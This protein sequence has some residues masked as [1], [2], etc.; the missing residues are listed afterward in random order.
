MQNV[1]NSLQKPNRMSEQKCLTVF[2]KDN[3][4]S[5]A[6]CVHIF[7]LPLIWWENV[8]FV[9]LMKAK[10]TCKWIKLYRL[11]YMHYARARVGDNL[12]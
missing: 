11:L 6:Q 9:L 5:L 8:N 7:C 2:L 4:W 3:K 10:V 12:Q 1:L